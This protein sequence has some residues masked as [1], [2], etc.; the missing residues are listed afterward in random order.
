LSGLCS[1]AILFPNLQVKGPKRIGALYVTCQLFKIYFRLGTV[2]LCRSVIRS[3]ETARNFD[4]EDF[5]VK[6]KVR[7]AKI[8]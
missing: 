4:F 7:L 2:H 3:I 8:W 6:D 1:E 5:P